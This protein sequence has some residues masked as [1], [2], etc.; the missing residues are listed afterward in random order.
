[1]FRNLFKKTVN[2]SNL[3]RIAIDK[4][5]GAHD[6]YIAFSNKTKSLSTK[7]LLE[8]L[9]EEELIHKKR[10]EHINVHKTKFKIK[11]H[12]TRLKELEYHLSLT[13]LDELKEVKD[14]FIQAISLEQ[15]SQQIYSE[16]ATMSENRAI[17]QIFRSL[18]I[19]EQKH[20]KLLEETLRKL[21]I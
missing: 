1:M 9:A 3:M 4:E 18:I 13:P 2:V 19:E 20:E 6:F 14:A 15:E 11:G 16:L 7:I 17:A 8:K 10:L 5:Q 12:E 21:G